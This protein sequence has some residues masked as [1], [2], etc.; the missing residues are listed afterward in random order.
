MNRVIGARIS[1]DVALSL[2][3]VPLNYDDELDYELRGPDRAYHYTIS[4]DGDRIVEV[5]RHSYRYYY[6][7][8]RP[9]HGWEEIR[10]FPSWVNRKVNPRVAELLGRSRLVCKPDEP[11]AGREADSKALSAVRK[12]YP[13]TEIHVAR[14]EAGRVTALTIDGGWVEYKIPSE[15]ALLSELERLSVSLCRA[16]CLPPEIG[17]LKRLKYLSIGQ[18]H[19]RKLPE[20]MGRLESLEE[21]HLVDNELRTVPKCICELRSLR[22]LWLHGNSIWRCSEE[23]GNLTKLEE[24]SV[25]YSL[26][27]LPSSIGQ[28][29]SLKKLRLS[30]NK[31]AVLPR[32]I[33]ALKSLETLDLMGN[34]L[35]CLPDEIRELTSLKQ[36]MLGSNRLTKAPSA[37]VKL[38]ALE[39]VSLEGNQIKRWPVGF[40]RFGY[41]AE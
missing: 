19:L 33:G 37:I 14:N 27:A 20:E 1:R 4:L 22:I 32:E 2:G 12:A 7:H 18:S 5:K 34:K 28:L 9:D 35:S 38:P 26:H 25:G 15:V 16:C 36:L 13:N 21:L 24:L 11:D 41:P 10:S 40:K 3:F 8:G 30:M 31:L 23:I 6:G 39:Y 29:V 17:G